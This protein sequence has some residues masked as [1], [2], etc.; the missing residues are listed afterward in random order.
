MCSLCQIRLG[1]MIRQRRVSLL[2][3]VNELS[4]RAILSPAY[5]TSIEEGQTF[6]SSSVIRKIA[7]GLRVSE[8]VLMVVCNGGRPLQRPY[9]AIGESLR[10][11]GISE[12]DGEATE[13]NDLR[14]RPAVHQGILE[15]E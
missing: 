12:D 14:Q 8:A 7:C 6:P 9:L 11:A 15:V 13:S 10:S 3:T 1:K 2:M 5:L 4:E